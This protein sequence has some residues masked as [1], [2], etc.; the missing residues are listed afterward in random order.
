MSRCAGI[1]ALSCAA[2]L[3]LLAGEARAEPAPSSSE[4]VQ[5]ARLVPLPDTSLGYLAPTPRPTLAWL[6]LQ[7]VPSPE[8]AFGGQRR[9]GPTGEVDDGVKTA[10]GLRWQLT[11]V[12]WSFGVHRSQP[13]FRYLI[14]DPIARHSGSIELSASIEYIGGHIDRVLVRPGLR[15]YLPILS[16]GESLAVSL[17]TS[18]YSYDGLRVAYEVGAYTFSGIFGVQ[19]TVAPTHAPLAA[20]A[21]FRVRYF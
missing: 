1:A 9:I 6:L 13:R 2:A 12:L 11:P 19:M 17:G 15:T 3:T 5:G 8:L 14:V 16:K 20:L 7:L 10:F 18:V 21:T 4:P